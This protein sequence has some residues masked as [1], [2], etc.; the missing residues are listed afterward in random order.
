M[1]NLIQ[2]I[3]TPTIITRAPRR[4][5]TKTYTPA[6]WRI[7]IKILKPRPI[8]AIRL[9]TLMRLSRVALNA[10][11]KNDPFCAYVVRCGN[12]QA[13]NGGEGSE[14]PTDGANEMVRPEPCIHTIYPLS[15]P[16]FRKGQL[17]LFRHSV[18]WPA[19]HHVNFS[20]FIFYHSRKLVFLTGRFSTK[21]KKHCG[22]PAPF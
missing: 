8:P 17:K 19:F 9:P 15:D 16:A 1:M 13:N 14:E 10:S 11:K 20:F 5:R 18:S 3:T 4:A 6:I 22:A 2:A 21:L 7:E 12:C